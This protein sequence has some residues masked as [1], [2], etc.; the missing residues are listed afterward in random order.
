MVLLEVLKSKK[1]KTCKVRIESKIGEPIAIFQLVYSHY[2]LNYII[3]VY[4]CI[5]IF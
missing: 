4:K 1:S 2:P 5:L 3:P